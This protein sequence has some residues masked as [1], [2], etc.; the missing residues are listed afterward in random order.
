MG[1][2]LDFD[3]EVDH[4]NFSVEDF[5]KSLSKKDLQSFESVKQKYGSLSPDYEGYFTEFGQSTAQTFISSMR[6]L[7]S[8][9]EKTGNPLGN[10]IKDYFNGVLARNQQWNEPDGISTAGKVARITGSAVGST[11]STFATTAAGTLLGGPKV[12]VSAGVV[13]VFS[14]TFGDNVERNLSAGYD[15]DKAYGMAFL[16]SGIE[17]WIIIIKD[18]TRCMNTTLIN[19][20]FNADNNI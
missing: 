9:L 17:K 6:G 19:K 8:T 4:S 5:S 3:E 16:E 14:Q 2:Y 7:G 1:T 10:I 20:S 15:E 11:A 13:T 12:G 18:C